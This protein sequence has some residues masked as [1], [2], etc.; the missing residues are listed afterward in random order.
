MPLHM[1]FETSYNIGLIPRESKFANTVPIYKKGSIA[2][3]KQ[4]A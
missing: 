1:I 3:L 2:K 4:V